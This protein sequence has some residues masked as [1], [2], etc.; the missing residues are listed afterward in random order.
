[1]LRKTLLLAAAALLC[2]GAAP[3][4]P[5][6]KAP[7]KPAAAKAAAKPAPARTSGYDAGDPNAFI[8]LL[9]SVDAKAQIARTDG[10]AVF[11]TVTSPTEVFSAQFAGC[12][13][14]GKACQA[15]L[16]DRL[17]AE[18][19][20]TMAQ[21]NGFNQ[22]SVMC[23]VYQDR[24]GKAHVEYSAL[25]FP[26]TNRDEMLM[27]LNAWRGCIADFADFAKD[28]TGFLANAA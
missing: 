18:G 4:K 19:S 27:H 28:P 7:A 6:P 2:M 10:D 5:A 11:M 20:P 9:A 24:S 23:R 1:M 21:I 12:N 8:S 3:A 16:F 13:P 17:G 14:Q 25:V 22:T 26:R 15:V